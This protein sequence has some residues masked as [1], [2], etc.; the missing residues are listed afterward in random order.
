M[1]GK[2]NMYE[3]V[4]V[5]R[6][7]KVANKR[8]AGGCEG[9]LRVLGFVFCLSAAVILGVDKQTKIVS[10]QLVPTLPPINVPAHAKWYYLSAFKY[11]VV[12]HAI[13]CSY[14]VLSLLLS[15][16]NRGGKRGNISLGIAMADIVMVALLFSSNGAAVS[17]GLM[18]YQGNSHV[19]WKKVC[20]V[21]GKFCHQAAAAFVVSALG[22]I[23][24]LLLIV[25]ALKRLHKKL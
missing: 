25:F 5:G 22:A 4:E 18:G 24:F 1:E 11:F 17:I 9:L 13:A 7:V 14:A 6:E 3:G 20:N 23:A 21:F 19:Q 16:G 15:L 12:A 8:G 2:S 10:L